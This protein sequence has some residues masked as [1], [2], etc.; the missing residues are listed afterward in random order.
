MTLVLQSV[1]SMNISTEYTHT[2]THTRIYIYIYIYICVCVCV[3]VCISHAY[4]P[5]HKHKP[6]YFLISIQLSI[7][8]GFESRTITKLKK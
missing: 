8:Q 5:T 3:C 7:E 6:T 2:Y 4:R 1:I